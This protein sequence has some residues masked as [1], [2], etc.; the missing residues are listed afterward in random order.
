ML[1]PPKVPRNARLT[2]GDQEAGMGGEP[3]RQPEYYGNDGFE[4]KKMKSN[5]S[6]QVQQ[7][8]NDQ[9]VDWELANSGYARILA[10]ARSGNR[11]VN[12]GGAMESVFDRHRSRM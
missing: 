8:G 1:P 11:D 7:K 9:P 2:I 6:I 5:N 12:S 3:T 4:F 10:E